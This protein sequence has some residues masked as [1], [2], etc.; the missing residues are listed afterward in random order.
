[1]EGWKAEK[2]TLLLIKVRREKRKVEGG[3]T[4]KF[5]LTV[6]QRGTTWP[7]CNNQSPIEIGKVEGDIGG[8]EGLCG[9]EKN[10]VERSCWRKDHGTSEAY[11]S[12]FYWGR[13]RE[14][15]TRFEEGKKVEAI[16][17]VRSLQE[18]N[19]NFTKRQG[20]PLSVG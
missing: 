18:K 12:G 7:V 13:M 17:E 2:G 19:R 6:S 20:D 4:S 8:E 14:K 15:I 3:K 1:V 5:P 16:R 9:G 11:R 10:T